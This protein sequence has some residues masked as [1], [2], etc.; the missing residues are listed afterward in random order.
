[1]LNNYL[2]PQVP[3]WNPQKKPFCYLIFT[4]ALFFFSIQNNPR[5]LSAFSRKSAYIDV[6][7][8]KTQHGSDKGKRQQRAYT[9]I[10]CGSCRPISHLRC[11]NI[12]AFSG[13]IRS[14][15]YSL[16]A[17]VFFCFFSCLFD[18]RSNEHSAILQLN[19]TDF[20]EKLFC[21]VFWPFCVA[22][23]RNLL[24]LSQQADRNL[25]FFSAKVADLWFMLRASCIRSILDMRLT[26]E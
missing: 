23:A 6:Y 13:R 8:C 22:L 4:A 25:F 24:V 26:G 15:Y 3:Q 14:G 21:R 7:F 10:L 11:Q 1:M 5:L 18:L 20:Q 9:L 2:S 19:L 12:S 17:S 16:S